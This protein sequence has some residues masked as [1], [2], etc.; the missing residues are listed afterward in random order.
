MSSDNIVKK[1]IIERDT[2]Y[3]FPESA[4]AVHTF[5]DEPNKL[6]IV[7]QWRSLHGVTTLELPGGRIEIGELPQTAAIREL[8]EEAGI[9]A[10]EVDYLLKLDMDFSASKHRTHLVRTRSRLP[11]TIKE[12][13]ILIDVNDAWLAVSRGDISHA[14]TVVAILLLITG[15]CENV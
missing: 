8:K 3:M 6:V 4:C 12:G 5:V 9:A 2:C 10:E 1:V 13:V 14:P 11:K 7:E 15:R